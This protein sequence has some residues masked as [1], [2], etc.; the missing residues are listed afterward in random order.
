QALVHPVHTPPHPLGHPALPLPV[1]NH[2]SAKCAGK[3]SARAPTSS[4][5]A[6]STAATGRSA[7]P[8]VSTASSAGWT[9]SATKRLSVAMDTCT[10]QSEDFVLCSLVPMNKQLVFFPTTGSIT[11][12]YCC[13]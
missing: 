1:R 5:T 7:A 3:D 9:C 12:D 11:P 10:L 8:A 13:K 2:T 6:E 4:P